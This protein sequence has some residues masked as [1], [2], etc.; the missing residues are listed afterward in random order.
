MTNHQRT[1]LSKSFDTPVGW[2]KM[3]SGEAAANEE[4]NRTSGRTLSF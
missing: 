2:S 1:N 4:A 3:S